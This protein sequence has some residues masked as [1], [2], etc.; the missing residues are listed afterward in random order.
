MVWEKRL[1]L[2]IK[3]CSVLE[4]E[5]G[6]ISSSHVWGMTKVPR[7]RLHGSSSHK[8]FLGLRAAT[9][10]LWYNKGAAFPSPSKASCTTQ[11]RAAQENQDFSDI[12]TESKA[13]D[14]TLQM[15]CA[16]S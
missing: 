12:K 2:N 7:A 6:I 11:S 1:M 3:F 10:C 9:A 15:A 5:N 14:N 8:S 4:T 16:C 13:V